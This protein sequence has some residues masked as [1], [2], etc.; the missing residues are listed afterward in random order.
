LNLRTGSSKSASCFTLHAEQNGL[1][2][3]QSSY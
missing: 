1:S 2:L 3:I